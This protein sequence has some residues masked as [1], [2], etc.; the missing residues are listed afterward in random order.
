MR[1]MT[2]ERWLQIEKI[3][4]EACH[5]GPAERAA[6]LRVA[7]AD[8]EELRG[9]IERLLSDANL[10]GNLL[11]TLARNPA[12]EKGTLTAELKKTAEQD[13]KH[14]CEAFVHLLKGVFETA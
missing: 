1:S 3:Y 7:C 12:P 6:F 4:D 8:D 13:W 11:T 9:E 10:P 5:L 2:P 14:F